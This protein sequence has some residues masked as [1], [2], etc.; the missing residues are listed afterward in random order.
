MSDEKDFAQY[1]TDYP[2]KRFRP[3]VWYNVDG[4]QIDG[5]IEDER[6]YSE[7][8]NDGTSNVMGI[9]RAMSDKRVVGFSVYSIRKVL[10]EAGFEMMKRENLRRS[11]AVMASIATVIG[12]IFGWLLRGV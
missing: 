6:A 8:V 9:D 11:V 7:E 4:D 2:R 12:A 10:R 3:Y 5:W 1:L